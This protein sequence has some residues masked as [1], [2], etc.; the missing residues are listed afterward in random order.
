MPW[1]SDFTTLYLGHKRLCQRP[2]FRGEGDI[3]ASTHYFCPDCGEI[4]AREIH[5]KCNFHYPITAK[6]I[7]CSPTKGG[8]FLFGTE[9]NQAYSYNDWKRFPKE[10]LLYELSIL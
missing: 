10:L 8:T 9:L 1:T 6:C 4:W 3:R 5:P 7:R 2:Y